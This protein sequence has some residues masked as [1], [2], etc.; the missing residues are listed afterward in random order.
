MQ[1]IEPETFPWGNR[2]RFH[3]YSDYLKQKH[4]FRIQKLSVDA[5]FTCPNRDGSKGYG[6]CVFCNNE[7]FNPSYCRK[8]E[9]IARQLEEGKRFHAWRYRHAG[10]YIAYFQSYSNTYAPLE[11]LKRHY[12]AALEVDGIIGLAIGTRPDCVDEE[13]LDY[14][15]ELAQCHFIHLEMGIESCYDRSLQWMNRGHDFATARSA[16]ERAAKR[17]LSTGTHLILGLPGLSRNQELAQA[18]II[19]SLPV[20]TLKLH[21]LQIIRHTELEKQ[22]LTRPETFHFFG[23]EEYIDFVVD[24]L[25]RLSPE[26]KMERFAAEAPPRFQAGPTFGHIRTDQILQMIEKRLEERNTYQGACFRNN[27]S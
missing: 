14:L 20:N 22:Y 3:A 2:R 6:G 27:L 9:D 10:R 21:Q 11:T 26:I 16:F 1:A 5:G 15:A 23:L 4:G 7:A 13:I 12:T 24:F 25:E 17:G 18:E 8:T 19:S